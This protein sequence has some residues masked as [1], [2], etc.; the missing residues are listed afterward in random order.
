MKKVFK[1]T[2]S[3]LM[4]TVMCLTMAPLQGFVGLD[5]SGWFAS[6]A[7]AAVV[8][9]STNIGVFQD[10][11]TAFVVV[12]NGTESY[13]Y[14]NKVTIDGKTY[15]T[16]DEDQISLDEAES[17]KN[18][19]VIFTEENNV[20][21]SISRFRVT[22]TK[23]QIYG[24]GASITYKDGWFSKK[25]FSVTGWI[26]NILSGSDVYRSEFISNYYNSNG[27]NQL[28]DIYITL[29]SPDKNKLYF[30]KGIF[31]G[32]E[33]EMTFPLQ[34]TIGAGLSDSFDCDI[35]VNRDYYPSSGSEDIEIECIL[36]GYLNGVKV[37]GVFSS[38]IVNITNQDFYK[39]GETKE[40]SLR[41]FLE[42][43]QGDINRCNLLK[44]GEKVE[45]S[46]KFASALGWDSFANFD[47]EIGML[48][49]AYDMAGDLSGIGFKSVESTGK[50][51]L[52]T[53]IKN[54]TSDMEDI[55]D[56]ADSQL[57]ELL[58]HKYFKI[59]IS[60]YEAQLQQKNQS[61]S[62][63]N[64]LCPTDVIVTDVDGNIVLKIINNEII[65]CDS[66]IYA[67]IVD[68][69]KYVY[70]PTDIEHNIEIIATD[71]GTMDYSVSAYTPAGLE[72]TIEYNDVPLVKDEVYMAVAPCESMSETETYNLVSETG[73]EIEA[74]YDSLLPVEDNIVDVIV[75]EE[76]FDGFPV[77]IID[78]VADTMFNMKSVVDLSAYDISTD[79]AVALFSAVAKYYPA[80]YSLIAN[81]D[82]TYKIIVSPNLDRIMKIRFYY[83]DDANLSTYQKRV[84]DLNA[85]INALVA[86]VEGMTEFEKALY[87][88][89][90]IV[91]H[92][93]YDMELLEYME[94]NNCIL[95]GEMRSEKY[96]E[97]SI[98]VN[99]TG[100]CGSYALAYRA[101]LNAAGMECL[102]LSSRSMNHAWNLV[103]IDGNWY[104]VD[105][106]WD[107]PV[108]D[109]Y[110]RARRTY[111]L[112]TDKEIMDLNHYSW[113][114]GQYKATSELFSDMP[115]NYDMKQKYDDGKW[116]YLTGSTLYSSDEYGKN[117][118]EITSISASSIDADNGNVYYSNGRYIYEY[119]IENDE[120]NL[121]YMLSN[122]DSGD[123]PSE[124]Y[125]SNI[126]VD[127]E[128]VD[129]YKSIYKDNKRITAYDTD[130]LQRERFES[131]TGIEINQSEVSL[132][133][134]ETLQLS[135][136]IIT[137]G[138]VE[139]LE[140]EWSSADN[141]I[142]MVDNSG[143]VTGK[144]IGS[145]TIKATFNQFQVF[146]SVQV[147]GDGLAGSIYK[148]TWN[149]DV[150]SKTLM[151]SGT[152]DLAYYSGWPVR[153]MWTSFMY[154]VEN[155]IIEDGITGISDQIFM[156]F[157]NL[158]NVSFSKT[159]KYIGRETFSNCK[160]IE[161]I[162][163]P[164]N[165]EE[166]GD[167][168][169]CECSSLRE[170]YIS[171]SVQA[172]GHDT[173]FL[174]NA[175]EKIEVAD[176]NA[177][178]SNDD[179]GVLYDKDKTTLIKY[180]IASDITSYDIPYG[181]EV[182][183]FE[184][185]RF[186]KNLKSVTFPET[187]RTIS[188]YAFSDCEFLENVYFDNGLKE[189]STCA[190]GECINLKQIDFPS[191]LKH[192]GYA[193]FAGTSLENVIIPESVVSI[194]ELC[195][196]RCK[197][198]KSFLVEADNQYYTS[199]NGVLYNKNKTE[200]YCY[201]SSSASESFDIPEGVNLISHKAFNY[202]QK[203]KNINIPE[204]VTTIEGSAFD[205][206][207]LLKEIFIPKNVKSVGLT[208]FNECLSLE[209]IEVDNENQ[210]FKNDKC[211]V[212]YNYVGTELLQ[213]PCGRKDEN[214]IVS[215]G[216]IEIKYGAFYKSVWL[217]NVQIPNTVT[218]IG[219]YAFYGCENLYNI[220]IPRYVTEF[221]MSAFKNC[222]ALE[223]IVIPENINELWQ[224]FDGCHKL[225][226]ILILASSFDSYY[227]GSEPI[228][229]AIY[230]CH[231]NSSVSNFYI[232]YGYTTENIDDLTNHTEHEYF[233]FDYCIPTEMRDGYEYWKCYC[234]ESTYTNVLHYYN[235]STTTEPTCTADGYRSTFCGNCNDTVVLEIT[236][237]TGKH[238]YKLIST[239]PG[240]CITAPVYTY[241]CSSCGD[242][243]TKEGKIEEGHSYETTV[244]SPTCDE[245]G[246]TKEMCTVC[247]ETLI[248]DFTSPLGHKFVINR[249]ADYC[250]AHGTLEYSCKNC[251]YTESVVSD[252][253]DL[254]TETVTVE[255]TCTKSGTKAEICTL[256]GATV[257]TE[258]LNPLSHDYAEEF[259]VDLE[260]TCT[261]A[262]R[263]SQHCTRCDAKR[264]V[265]ETAP[266]GHSEEIIPAMA[267]SCTATGLTEG[268]KCSA[269]GELL[270]AQEEVP[271]L[272]HAYNA[273]VVTKEPTCTAKGVKTFVCAN[274]AK[275]TYTEEIA[276]L[277]HTK[278]LV[279]A[280]EAT[281]TKNGYTGDLVCAD[282]GTV[283]EYG[284]VIPNTNGCSHLCHK[285]G[286]IGFIWKIVQ[287]FWKLFK[288]HPVCE[289]GAAHY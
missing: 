124:A 267:A 255:P 228:E 261:T 183:D 13:E 163:F 66:Y 16:Y 282:C 81:S 229:D 128:N 196:S 100:V 94:A 144:N 85:E 90:Y 135:A 207:T 171:E 151:I 219:W 104:H 110:G 32:K 209:F 165:L 202:A 281:A 237:A 56:F 198:I 172:I 221:G 280:K 45:L 143:L 6:E 54:I 204:S 181:V 82:F 23:P 48:E 215:D 233:L 203:L 193:S 205:K 249:S 238:N 133:V 212:L 33:C 273:G 223:K 65:S 149:Y 55:R 157:S 242:T 188:G 251:D 51:Y 14:V 260:A 30:D 62:L 160:K 84:N 168:A 184:A 241:T 126:Y 78:L 145:T 266:L 257:S 73:E 103:K 74:D 226:K 269:C 210:N 17:L 140:I 176:S 98:L 279:N 150:Q 109:T 67:F 7:K 227:I 9:S 21:V 191:T 19:K 199:D 179:F 164:V 288:M 115:R 276:K 5:M 137:T 101:V 284:K 180:P 134:F 175:I 118:T 230:Y 64:I 68:D 88:H 35:Y 93:E 87:I 95:P 105:C 265:T 169:F 248:S 130:L 39:K 24:N 59:Y 167:M 197:Y 92:S 286:F 141:N 18:N 182:I 117:E 155:V 254:V 8:T 148:G 218:K 170:I 217:K 142:A 76:L 245:K 127:N 72:R 195:F 147:T 107:D 244:V 178:Y 106:C 91:L 89:D 277:P 246:Y 206:C 129:Y 220:V 224:A 50:L 187:V 120:R 256:C 43:I 80:E 123:K 41:E 243:Y 38:F 125:L 116:Y 189:I 263:K 61:L 278:V 4:I 156:D 2:V 40:I 27:I 114:P 138:S 86:Q 36:N 236:P 211:G 47:D 57:Y 113:T 253:A 161:T 285:D 216:V 119:D 12:I 235:N 166:I 71:N 52:E 136:N 97:Y 1:K 185:F 268:K 58:N 53:I 250:S 214:Y 258:I 63:Y 44:S 252:E 34:R 247:G 77:E 174:C 213:Y 222:S 20:L 287:F 26:S 69:E 146:C 75:A 122:S 22:N 275:H 42:S 158:K 154:D 102:Y 271:A 60:W 46:L 201:P 111:F 225:S 240:T 272:G 194:G 49:V 132:D 3:V 231:Y 83:G 112:R 173:F 108:P 200:L 70:L 234:G 10:Y 152:A 131:I 121:V 259:T 139:D 29:K 239:L 37:E 79:D 28:T 159:I 232:K 274:D 25:K 289:C 153:S 15:P 31:Y 262:G 190:F 264:A 99:G 177:N 96:T 186:S 11:E 208:P 283:F 162:Q 192:I 270:T